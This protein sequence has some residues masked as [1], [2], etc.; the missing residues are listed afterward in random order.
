MG[1]P[2]PG[3]LPDPGIELM[4][5]MPPA[6]ASGF[7]T[8]STTWKAYIYIYIY[9]YI[10][11][12]FLLTSAISFHLHVQSIM[13]FCLLSTKHL[14]NSSPPAILSF[15]GDCI[16]ALNH[17]PAC[18][19]SPCEKPLLHAKSRV[20][21]LGKTQPLS[22]GLKTS[23]SPEDKDNLHFTPR[24]GHH[25]KTIQTILTRSFSLG[26]AF[27]PLSCSHVSD[28]YWNTRWFCTCCDFC[29]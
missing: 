22:P 4:S 19:V 23:G 10:S 15:L 2:P 8:T 25:Q 16:E 29:L 27:C 26:S 5:L 28:P 7:F 13:W 1:C 20:V 21:L 11:L 18:P 24:Q 12:F 6:L 14:L 17:F 9:P 3:N